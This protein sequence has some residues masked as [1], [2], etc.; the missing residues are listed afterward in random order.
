MRPI[1]GQYDTRLDHLRLFAGA[2]VVYWHYFN[3]YPGI[4]SAQG[5]PAFWPLSL[6]D[7]GHTGVSLFITLSGFLF[8]RLT[9]G[10]TIDYRG[11]IYNRFIRIAPLA[12]FWIALY[13]QMD[14]A[15][16]TGDVLLALAT[17]VNATIVVEFQCYL[18]FPLLRKFSI[19]FGV[20]YL[21]ALV[22]LALALRIMFTLF[23]GS[24]QGAAYLTIVGRFDQF[25][26]GMILSHLSI[27]WRPNR[28][29]SGAALLVGLTIVT[30][31]IHELNLLGGV[32]TALKFP[33]SLYWAFLPTLEGL[34]WGFVIAGYTKF[35]WEHWKRAGLALAWAG[36][37]SYS[38]YWGHIG[39]MAA[40]NGLTNFPEL[41]FLNPASP[42]GLILRYVVV[43][44]PA[45]I[46][47]SAVTYY[48]I[49][50]PF[51]SMRKPYLSRSAPRVPPAPIRAV[52]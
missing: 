15:N 39:V 23:T 25:L 33:S 41:A 51:L 17:G 9:F 32:Q 52:A 11:F 27:V 34:G 24:V 2:L 30:T 14:G 19:E 7:E 6:F 18:L 43:V 49:E 20:R 10:Q 40:I 21:V 38:I 13:M 44:M 4:M 48:L 36:G 26:I 22:A 42:R 3:R 35:P 16:T 12:I 28:L 37:L 5:V 8:Y 46:A 29:E 47:F 50:K 45:V 31:A 1:S